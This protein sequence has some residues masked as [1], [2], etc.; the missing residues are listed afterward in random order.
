MK[1]LP[2]WFQP[3][4]TGVTVLV[5]GI[6]IAGILMVPY[7]AVQPPHGGD[8]P[9]V[10]LNTKNST[11]FAG[12]DLEQVAARVSQ[13]VYPAAGQ[14]NS[15]EVV[16]LYAPHDWQAGLAAAPLLR[17]ARGVLLPAT[18]DVAAEIERLRPTG[19]D[20]FSGAG[21]IRIGDWEAPAGVSGRVYTPEELLELRLGLSP[22]PRHVILVSPNDPGTALL[23]APWAAF[24]GDLIVFTPLDAP[25]GIPLYALGAFSLDGVPSIG[26]ADPAQTAAAFAAYEDPQN[27]LFGW[28]M[29]ASSLTGYRAYSVANLHLPATALLSANLAVRG[30]PGPLL[31]SEAD[32]L[33][34]AVNNYLWSQRAAFWVT[35]SEGPFHHFWILGDEN[36]V[37]FAAQGQA[38]YAVEIGPY[39]GKGAGM[40]GID[41]LAAAWVAIGLA[42][43]FWIAVHE[44]KF[45]PYQNW[46]MRLAWP[47]LA[48][49]LGPFGLVMY[50]LAYS[51]PVIQHDQMVMW[52]RPLWLQGL[53]ATASAVGFGA[54]LM[55]VTGFIVTLF[56][57]PLVPNRSALFFLGTPM[58]LVMIINYLV[59]VVVSWLVFQTP[60]LAMF[61]NAGYRETL[62]KAFPMVLLSMTAAALAM[63]P[64]M[65][66]LM[67][68]KIPMAP[69]EE[70]ILWFGVMFFTGFLAFL[71]AW[72]LN[73]VLVRLQRKS[74]LM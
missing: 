22:E 37:S 30:K 64:G 31:W 50:Y 43:A 48:L 38:D 73:Y 21:V 35:P 67:M 40:S 10:H 51:R 44:V 34:V 62:G 28:G 36:A 32:R 72:P 53:V 24:S 41:L 33:P 39:L 12:Q 56:G 20:L 66:W 49:M 52:D 6:L 71:M 63:N 59:A 7:R 47:L 2:K 8:Q 65:W 45:L 19:S 5:A 54:S 58:I 23:A 68:W 9:R 60:M 1:Q 42:S 16:F 18:A 29:N 46:I 27:P 61:Y 13:A 25:E 15:P 4:A 55:I 17:L 14:A 11:R 69:T 26:N 70:S 57:M 74:G 3:F